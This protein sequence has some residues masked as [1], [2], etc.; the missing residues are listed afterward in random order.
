MK[1]KY[2]YQIKENINKLFVITNIN[3]N[4]NVLLMIFNKLK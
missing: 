1:I 4:E 3:Y 2:N